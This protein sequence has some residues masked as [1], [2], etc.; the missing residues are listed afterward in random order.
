MMTHLRVKGFTIF[1]DRHGRMRWDHHATGHKI[2]L[3]KAT[4]ENE[5]ARR[6][7]IVKP[8]PEK[9]QTRSE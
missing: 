5:N 7:K 4:L 8:V 2:D 9:R 6:V 1:K 3:T